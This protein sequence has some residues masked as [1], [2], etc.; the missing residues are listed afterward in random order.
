[1]QAIQC[2]I[3]K[4]TVITFRNPSIALIVSDMI[5][6]SNLYSSFLSFKTLSNLKNLK[7]LTILISLNNYGAF[8][9]LC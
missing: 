5:I 3:N 7:N 8:E 1:M 6:S 9:A 4:I 2:A